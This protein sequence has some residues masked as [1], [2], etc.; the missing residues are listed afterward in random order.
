M[1]FILRKGKSV[2]ENWPIAASQVV[3]AGDLVYANGSGT[4]I[5]ADSTSGDHLG[6]AMKTIASTDSDYAVAKSLPV[7]KAYADN[8]YE[9]DVDTG[10]AL[11]AAMVGNQYDL[12][13]ANSLNVGATSK[14]VVTIVGFISATKALVKINAVI[15]NTHVVTS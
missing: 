13:D 11:T 5:P 8:I 15:E 9:V 12:T 7:L 2:I 4:V 6:I 3:V 1:A 14:K 10:T